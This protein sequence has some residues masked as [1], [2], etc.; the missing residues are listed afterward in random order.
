M[1]IP[2]MRQIS[3]CLIIVISVFSVVPRVDAAFSPSEAIALQEA[4]RMA[5][6]ETVQKALESKIVKSRLKAL[7]FTEDEVNSRLDALSDEQLHELAL[8]VD[9]L[10]VGGDAIGVVLGILII[11]ILVLV[12]LHY[13]G[14][15]VFVTH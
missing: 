14:H 15:K 4:S 8:K 3:W 1:A 7:G 11:V 6:L 13:T 9:D 2:F 10:M 12:I 5:D